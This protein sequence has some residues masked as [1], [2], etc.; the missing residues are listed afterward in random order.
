MFYNDSSKT[1]F[2]V[3]GILKNG[4]RS[5]LK[6]IH[7][8]GKFYIS[9]N[10]CAFDSIIHVLCTSYCDSKLYAEFVNSNNDHLMFKLI[11]N[12]I[13]DGINVQTYR[14]RSMILSKICS[15]KELSEQLICIQADTTIEVMARNLLENWPSRVDTQN[16]ISCPRQQINQQ[17]ILIS[18]NDIQN[19]NMLLMADGSVNKCNQCN[20]RLINPYK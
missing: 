3:I 5:N 14:K 12:A 4:N 1:T 11:I 9:S 18:V 17:P 10:T 8:D 20:R 2:P 19:L 7:I 6:S 16:C 13:K 15:L